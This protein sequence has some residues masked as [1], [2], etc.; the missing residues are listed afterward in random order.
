MFP[1]FPFADVVDQVEKLGSKKLVQNCIKRVRRGE[2]DIIDDGE[3]SE[4]ELDAQDGVSRDDR[5][6]SQVPATPV[7]NI[8]QPFGV[9][10]EPRNGMV[11]L[12]PEQ[13]ER[14][15]LNRERALTKRK[16]AQE[17]QIAQENTPI[18]EQKTI[19]EEPAK[20]IDVLET[21]KDVDSRAG[22]VGVEHDSSVQEND[23]EMFDDHVDIPVDIP[24]PDGG[25]SESADGAGMSISMAW[26][27]ENMR[28]ED[29][30]MEN[31]ETTTYI[32]NSNDI[33]QNG[34]NLPTVQDVVVSEITKE[35]D[36]SIFA[37]KGNADSGSTF[38]EG[39]MP[40]SSREEGIQQKGAQETSE[41]GP[42]E[43]AP[44]DAEVEP[45]S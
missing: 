5:T 6:Q 44:T 23:V 10:A 36:L 38:C 15:R 31:A 3:K 40:S 35:N 43:Q 8:V 33:A 1:K 37:N 26:E 14:I 45:K 28:E 7:S 30:E 16:A 2:D 32:E 41:T 20:S 4:T 42:S 25:N 21:V 18:N 24:L 27:N 19:I 17:N 39:E 12:T 13:Q 22:S 29:T 34:E 9:Q 11:I